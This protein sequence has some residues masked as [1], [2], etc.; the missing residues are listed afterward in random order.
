MKRVLLALSFSLIPYLASAAVGINCDPQSMSWNPDWRF[1]TYEGLADYF[2]NP[3]KAR[4]KINKEFKLI[5]RTF[6]RDEITLPHNFW[7]RTCY[8]TTHQMVGEYLGYAMMADNA[9]YDVYFRFPRNRRQIRNNL[10]LDVGYWGS[11]EHLMADWASDRN[12][13]EVS[14]SY[15]VN[16][17]FVSEHVPATTSCGT[18][19]STSCGPLSRRPSYGECSGLASNSYWSYYSAFSDDT[20]DHIAGGDMDY[21]NKSDIIGCNDHD[22][23]GWE[24]PDNDFSQSPVSVRLQS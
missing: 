20:I 13:G 22:F 18:L 17:Y 5:I 6:G 15:I 14:G 11:V 1:C 16:N 2:N 4:F 23:F 10:F 19:E 12:N 3:T 8:V 21:Y 9:H 7:P 24:I